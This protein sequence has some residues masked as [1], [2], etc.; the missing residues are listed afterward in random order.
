MNI[1]SS[2]LLGI[3]QGATE[4]LPVSS[5][6]HLVISSTLLGQSP[7]L[8]FT[9]FLHLATLLAVCAYFYR[10]IINLLRNL[11]SGLWQIIIKKE[12]FHSIYHSNTYFKMAWLLLLGS[13][14]TGVVGMPLRN[15]VAAS[16]RSTLAVGL[17]L[18]V[19]AIII[20]LAEWIGTGKR[21]SPQ[22]NFLD[23]MS[24]GIAQGIAVFPGISR[25]GACISAS[26]ARGL[27]RKLAASFSFL[28][29]IPVILGSGL[30]E[31]KSLIIMGSSSNGFLGLIAGFIAAFVS[32]YLA[33]KIFMNIIQKMSIRIFAYYCLIVGVIVIIWSL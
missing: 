2:V 17:F 32:G 30:I 1:P 24:I 21:L 12:A 19:T 14:F 4:F 13:I 27:E 23:A 9:V 26:L 8:S 25:A 29:S 31:L 10:E 16:F 20:L 28:I 7:S 11:L 6:G 22:M 33:I 15:Y 5:S 18:I 3:I